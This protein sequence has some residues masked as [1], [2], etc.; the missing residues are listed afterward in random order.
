MKNDL[1]TTR[2]DDNR[3][4]RTK[5]W[6]AIFSTFVSIIVLMVL[7]IFV[8][9]ESIE[10]VQKEQLSVQR[11]SADDEKALAEM[12][13]VKGLH[14]MSAQAWI[15]YTTRSPL[16]K[17]DK[18][19]YYYR[20]GRLFQQGKRYDCALEYFYRSDLTKR[21]PEI[22]VELRQHMQECF[23]KLGIDS[24][25]GEKISAQKNPSTTAP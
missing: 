16:N 11:S 25:T 12:L 23:E 2:P 18:A 15:R 19:G 10:K 7:G 5:P 17:K 24:E 14:L 22:R 3:P 1:N 8:V 21:L 20:I 4:R 9:Q 6:F 13:E